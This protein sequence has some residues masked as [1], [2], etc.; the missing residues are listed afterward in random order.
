MKKKNCH[1]VFSCRI[2]DT[3]RQ[4]V[5]KFEKKLLLSLQRRRPSVTEAF[6]NGA[7]EVNVDVDDGVFVDTAVAFLT[8]EVVQRRKVVNVLQSTSL[9]IFFGID[10][11]VK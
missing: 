5:Q 8:K 9:K 1:L 11:L 6:D 3:L 2:F 10:A 7:M 4:K